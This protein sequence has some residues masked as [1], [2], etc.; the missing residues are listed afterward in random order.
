MGRKIWCPDSNEDINL[1]E[2][3]VKGSGL[4]TRGLSS[5]RNRRW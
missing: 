5:A 4:D 2:D 1:D 3:S